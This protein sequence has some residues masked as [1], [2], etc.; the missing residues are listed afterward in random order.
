[1]FR[2]ADELIGRLN[3]FIY[4]EMVDS[5]DLPSYRRIRPGEIK[6]QFHNK[7]YQ[8]RLPDG[9]QIGKLAVF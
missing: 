1:M 7:P 8:K 6:L 2:K 4:F 3:R 9:S 5:C